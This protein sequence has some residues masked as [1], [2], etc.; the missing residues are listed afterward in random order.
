MSSVRGDSDRVIR[1][2]DREFRDRIK[3]EIFIIAEKHKL[4]NITKQKL[5]VLL[6][7]AFGFIV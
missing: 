4:N 5:Y 2:L 7:E 1:K 6:L 3:E